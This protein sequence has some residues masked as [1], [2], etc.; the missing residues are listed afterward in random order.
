MHL[1]ATPRKFPA[2]NYTDWRPSSVLASSRVQPYPVSYGLQTSSLAV[3]PLWCGG[4]LVELLYD[5]G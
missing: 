3:G 5:Q 1:V 4:L 2:A